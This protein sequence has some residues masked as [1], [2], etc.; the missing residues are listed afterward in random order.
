MSPRGLTPFW[1]GQEFVWRM[2]APRHRMHRALRIQRQMRSVVP[3]RYMV[4]SRGAS[5]LL[6]AKRHRTADDCSTESSM[7]NKGWAWLCNGGCVVRRRNHRLQIVLDLWRGRA[8][9]GAHLRQSGARNGGLAQHLD[10]EPGDRHIERAGE[11]AAGQLAD[12]VQFALGQVVMR[13][14]WVSRVVQSFLA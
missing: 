14:V 3:W 5:S 10:L 11:R 13:W 8:E 4:P 1:V 2:H 12:R 6:S 9:T 7:V